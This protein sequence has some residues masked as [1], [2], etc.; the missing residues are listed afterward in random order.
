MKENEEKKVVNE[1]NN[2]EQVQPQQNNVVNQPQNLEN[3]EQT[4]LQNQV[5]SQ[6]SVEKQT[7]EN[8]ENSKQNV[9]NKQPINQDEGNKNNNDSPVEDDNKGP[10]TFAKV[11]TTLLFIFLFTF[12]YFLGDITE[13][14]NQKKLEKES[15]EM[16]SGKL[17]CE[18]TKT[19]DNL[20]IR[21]SATFTFENKGITVLNY[22][23]TSNGDKIKDK[24]DLEKLYTDCKT[25]KEEVKTYSGVNIVCSLNSGVNT[26]KQTFNYANLKYE[27]INSAYSEAGGVYPQFKYKDDINSVESKMIAADYSC[28]K[29]R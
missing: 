15:A 18:N 11:M 2:S 27:E 17:I 23:T 16:L 19:T 14:I 22:T 4:K 13:F 10:S 6:V 1:A 9:V 8:Q 26:V 12:V 3:V 24:K 20:D 5:N 7:I 28:E 29:V 25:L 21:I